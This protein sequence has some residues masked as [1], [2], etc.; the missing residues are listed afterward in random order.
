MAAQSF[1]G[2][3]HE[4]DHIVRN[5]KSRAKKVP[6]SEPHYPLY[7]AYQSELEAGNLADRHDLVRNH[8]L[9]IRAETGK[10]LPVDVLLVDNVQ[11]AT[12]IQLL[13]I[14]AHLAAG[15]RV[16]MAGDDD[17]T[18]FGRDGIITAMQTGCG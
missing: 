7:R 17:I 6:E 14:R 1:K 16:I 2:T 8:L 10:P 5:Y 15:T 12:E 9:A 11:D 4:A 13:W 18:A 3:V